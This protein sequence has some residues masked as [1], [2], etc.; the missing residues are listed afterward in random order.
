MKEKTKLRLSNGQ[1]CIEYDVQRCN[2]CVLSNTFPD[3]TFDTFGICSYCTAL[4]ISE[5]NSDENIDR[6]RENIC[7]KNNSVDI[8]HLF[9]GGK[10]S[11]Y[12][13]YHLVEQGF[14]VVAMTYDNGFIAPEAIQNI[15]KTANL[16]GVEVV[17]RSLNKSTTHKL[18]REGLMGHDNAEALK[19][20]T[21]TCGI[22]ISTVLSLGAQEAQ[23]RNVGYMS[24]GWTP[25]QFTH[26]SVVAGSFIRMVCE[27]HF[28]PLSLR[29]PTL[30]KELNEHG[31]IEPKDYPILFNPLYILDYSES[32][33]MKK[34]HE[35]GWDTPKTTD[36]CSTNCLL[37]GYLVL[38]HT[39][40]HG[41]HPYEYELAHHVRT[42]RL[43]R[44]EALQK[45]EKV[46]VSPDAMDRVSKTLDLPPIS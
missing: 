6:L 1:Y 44:S 4:P 8:I 3:I 30:K 19:Y 16:L 34:L 28:N 22:C 37:N 31:L 25:G 2:K 32:A 33:V 21:A 24:G 38:E 9:S 26:E 35:I 42:G 43:D 10:D 45:I 5:S 46:R 23:M 20:S 13:L 15:E 29:N 14:R 7:D 12:A 27:G 36:S 11:T 39:L 40:R 17:V 18:M 41:F